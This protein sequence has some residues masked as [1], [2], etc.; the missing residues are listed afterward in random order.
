MEEGKQE[1]TGGRKVQWERE[2]E[3]ESKRENARERRSI[4]LESWPPEAA[5]CQIKTVNSYGD[6]IHHWPWAK[7]LFFLPVG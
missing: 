5:N 2:R 1:G 3:R 6:P 7:L 4:I